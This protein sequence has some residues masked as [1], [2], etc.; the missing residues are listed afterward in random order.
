MNYDFLT[1]EDYNNILIQERFFHDIYTV[2]FNDFELGV[3][4]TV[5]IDDWIVI[6]K[7]DDDVTLTANNS[8]ITGNYSVVG[9]DYT[10]IVENNYLKLTLTNISDCI[11]RIQLSNIIPFSEKDNLFD[12]IGLDQF[13]VYPAKQNVHLTVKDKNGELL[14]GSVS[15]DGEITYFTNGDLNVTVN[16]KDKEYILLEIHAGGS[17]TYIPIRCIT[18]TTSIVIMQQDILFTVNPFELEF[19]HPSI[20]NPKYELYINN[21]LFESKIGDMGSD[22]VSFEL[23]G[24]KYDNGSILNIKLIINNTEYLFELPVETFNG[25]L[26]LFGQYLYNDIDFNVFNVTED[27]DATI[28]F[29]SYIKEKIINNTLSELN[30]LPM[31][32]LTAFSFRNIVLNDF[33]FKNIV[34][35]NPFISCDVVSPLGSTIEVNDAIFENVNTDILNKF[36]NTKLIF[37]NCTFKN[38]VG[39]ILYGNAT[40]NN[41]NFIQTEPNLKPLITI[42]DKVVLNRCSF[43]YDFAVDVDLPMDFYIIG[44]LNSNSKVNDTVLTQPS[45]FPMQNITVDINILFNDWKFKGNNGM[46]YGHKGGVSYYNLEVERR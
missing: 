2:D 43:V 8:L 35:S 37:N 21:K 28:R 14:D 33:V 30:N 32:V 42:T 31:F 7:N 12:I 4:N 44:G 45:G 38:C 46:I 25:S 27:A 36:L 17:I 26:K 20:D 19:F 5:V 1:L 16:A 15:V 24:M 34:S 3:N 6:E 23:D 18:A 40:F 39:T 11:V 9:A 29:N 22:N 13:I 10:A 41:C